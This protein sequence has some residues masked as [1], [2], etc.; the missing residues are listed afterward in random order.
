MF[1]LFP[2]LGLILIILGLLIKYR[3][4][5]WLISGYN[6]ATEEQKSK[7]DI[8]KLGKLTGN[9]CF[10]IALI[11]FASGIFIK[12]KWNIP[13]MIDMGLIFVVVP[14][15]VI[16]A[17]KYDMN[18]STGKSRIVAAITVLFSILT[19]GF[20]GGL[21]F[22]G[23]AEAEV[24]VAS[25][26]IHIQGMYGTDIPVKNITGITLKDTLPEILTKTNG[27]DLGNILKGNFK[28]KDMGIGKL[29]VHTDTP[30]YI[31]IAAGK[32][33]FIINSA[34]PNTTKSLYAT[35]K[36]VWER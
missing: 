11:L 22:Y 1:I 5:Y 8:T 27:F 2:I 24:T 30:P 25:E 21:L 23:S 15:A 9:L 10:I 13:F 14:Y 4:C 33:Y 17:Q 18:P 7:M 12:L 19:V 3:K 34:D 28:L 16:K 20:V 26:Q 32:D 35:M 31:Y 29:F 6:T 36:A